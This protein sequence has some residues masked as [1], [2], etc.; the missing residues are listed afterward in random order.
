MFTNFPLTPPSASTF[1]AEH[2]AIF[3]TL[4]ALTVIFSLIVGFA[5]L[6]FVFKYRQGSAA[7]RSR[8]VY[9]DGRLEAI[10]SIGPLIIALGMFFWGTKLFIT[11][12]VPPK[13]AQEIFVIGKQWMWHVQHSNGVRE[14]NTIHVPAGKPF[15]LTMISQDVIHAFYIPAFRTQMHVV[16]GRY[17]TLWFNATK[18][19]K[20][21]LFCSMY[22]GTQH[23]EMV[24]SIVVME[25]REWANWIENGGQS[26]PPLTLEQ[27]GEKLYK[28]L[29][30][31][32][33]HGSQDNMRAPSLYG[34][35]GKPRKFANGTS[36]IATESY[37]RESILR[38]HN[39]ISNGYS[40]TMPVYDGQINEEDVLK[41]MAYIKVVGSNLNT[42]SSSGTS[43]ESAALNRTR[44]TKTP[45]AINAIQAQENAIERIDSTPIT[46]SGEL[47][48]NAIAAQQSNGGKP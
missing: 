20:Y 6:Y 25:P 17:T 1:A 46:R 15:K 10:W 31:N 29:A 13:D 24:G 5:V 43:M 34:L 28:Q 44:G 19:G 27:A 36:E 23:S 18:P 26:Q 45:T 11:Q 39:K 42:P 4:T 16:P 40:N 21:H 48:A 30:C 32:N 7:D 38:P 41:L 12:R 33:C 22:C 37:I 9:E 8:P 47:A 35:L 14:N 2:D 3:Y